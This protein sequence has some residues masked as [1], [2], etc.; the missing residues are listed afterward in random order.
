LTIGV[1]QA[2]IGQPADIHLMHA[3]AAAGEADINGLD[4]REMQTGKR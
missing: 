2:V 1:F 4:Y 3:V